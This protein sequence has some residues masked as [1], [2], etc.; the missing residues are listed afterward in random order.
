MPEIIIDADGWFKSALPDDKNDKGTT[1]VLGR[2]LWDK[3][4]NIPASKEADHPVYKRV[5]AVQHKVTGSKDVSVNKVTKE[6]ADRWINRFPEA[7]EAFTSLD[8]QIKV[9]G[10]PLD[11]KNPDG[12]MAIDG[13][14]PEKA[15]HLLMEGIRSME[16][17]A[18]TADFICERLGFGTKHMRAEVQKHLKRAEQKEKGGGAKRLDGAAELAKVAAV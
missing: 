7:W 16:D 3:I 1:V 10:T 14:S 9:D 17:F 15:K 12:T 4:P 8:K 5:L 13:M 18:V 6:N 2:F 11:L